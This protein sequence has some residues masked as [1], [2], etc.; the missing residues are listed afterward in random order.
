MR[1]TASF[2]YEGFTYFICFDY[3]H[4]QSHANVISVAAIESMQYLFHV[5]MVKGE[6]FSRQICIFILINQVIF[7]SV[8]YVCIFLYFILLITLTFFNS[9]TLMIS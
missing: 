4:P 3:L 8:S 1:W 5:L 2:I 7:D 6:V 9:N